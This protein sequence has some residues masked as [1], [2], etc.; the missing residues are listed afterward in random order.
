MK[1]FTRDM[2]HE[3]CIGIEWP[4]FLGELRIGESFTIETERFNLVNGPIAIKGILAGDA[5]AVHIESI[6]MIPPFLSPNGG[7]FFEGMGDSVPLEYRDGKFHFPNGLTLEANPSV[8]NVAI[9][10]SPTE[11]ALS[12]SRRDLGPPGPKHRGWGWRG[13]VNDPR[14]KHCHQDCRSLGEGSIIHHKAQVNEAGLCLADVHGFIS[15]GELAFAG[16]EVAAR[17]QIR[18][19]KSEGWHIDW[20]LIETKDEIMV[21]CSDWDLQDGSIHREY[22][23]VVRQ[24][25]HEMRLVVSEKIKSTI[26]DANS[27]VASALDIRNC[28]LYGLGNFIQKDGKQSNQQDRDIAVVGVLP[29]SI[30]NSHA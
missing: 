7:P 8:G 17:V 18:V 12:F 4:E 30:F 9:L 14:G 6:D 13:L 19:E 11:T 24:A 21:F 23:D 3:H 16:I 22:V 5:I 25:Y 2:I 26:S 15:Q 10:P 29:K 27:I 1:I 20:P 28:A